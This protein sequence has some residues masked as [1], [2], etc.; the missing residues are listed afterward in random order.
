[1]KNQSFGI[2]KRNVIGFLSGTIQTI[3]CSATALKEK[4]PYHHTSGEIFT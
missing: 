3:I 1:M 2:L 4:E